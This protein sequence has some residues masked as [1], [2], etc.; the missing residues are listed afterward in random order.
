MGKTAE[1]ANY[2]PLP[3]KTPKEQEDIAF[4]WDAFETNCKHGKYQFTSRRLGRPSQLT[5]SNLKGDQ[6]G[7]VV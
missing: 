6:H 1:L 7:T 4:P 2:L 3:F 5:R